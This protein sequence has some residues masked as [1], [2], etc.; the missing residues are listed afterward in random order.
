[1]KRG[2]GT[3]LV[4]EKCSVII[5]HQGL[6][7]VCGSVQGA[8][9]SAKLFMWDGAPGS[10][11]GGEGDRV[12]SCGQL[13]LSPG[14]LYS[15]FHAPL[16][17]G[18]SGPSTASASGHGPRERSQGDGLRMPGMAEPCLFFSHRLLGDCFTYSKHSIMFVEGGRV[19]GC[20]RKRGVRFNHMDVNHHQGKN[21]LS[22]PSTL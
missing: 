19:W 16:A 14:H 9:V 1:M 17:E 2:P 10:P 5:V 6:C 18:V 11:R 21:P 8:G 15:D 4:L 13:G 7:C 20:V 12:F 22:L 3:G